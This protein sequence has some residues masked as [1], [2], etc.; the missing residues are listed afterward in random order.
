M[1]P[2]FV[3]LM[4]LR[5]SARGGRT[6]VRPYLGLPFPDGWY[7]VRKRTNRSVV[8]LSAPFGPDITWSVV[9]LS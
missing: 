3:R 7:Q 4:A 9:A 6:G 8:A 1:S 5:A 2:R